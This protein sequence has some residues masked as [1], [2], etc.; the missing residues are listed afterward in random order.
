MEHEEE[1]GAKAFDPH[2]TARLLKYLRPYRLRA[3]LSVLLVIVSSIFEIAGPAITAVAIDL[4]VKPLRGAHP[5][6][7]SRM[8]GDWL[9]AHGMN[10]D[11]LTGINVA[12]ALYVFTLVGGFAILYTQMVLM[13]LMGQ[14]VM[15]DMRKEIF[16]HLQGLDIQFFDRNPVGRLMTRVTTDVD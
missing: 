3:A 9:A 5:L 6:G 7:V 8:L 13:N 15:Y 14:Y 12:A 4:Y 11:P 10:F 1:K 16:Q 2:L